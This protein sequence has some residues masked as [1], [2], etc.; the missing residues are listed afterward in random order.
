MANAYTVPGDSDTVHVSDAT[1][2][3]NGGGNELQ[4]IADLPKWLRLGIYFTP[5][6]WKKTYI[7]LIVFSQLGSSVPIFS[8]IRINN[9]PSVL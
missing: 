3:E 7:A 1:R 4:S 5:A 9:N 2:Y 8:Y 6:R